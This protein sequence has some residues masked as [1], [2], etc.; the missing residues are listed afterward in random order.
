MQ[1]GM[2]Q[3]QQQHLYTAVLVLGNNHTLP[4]TAPTHMTSSSM[5]HTPRTLLLLLLLGPQQ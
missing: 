5:Q 1:Q 4:A 2:Q 3:H